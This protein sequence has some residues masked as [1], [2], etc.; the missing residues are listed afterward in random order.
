MVP[1]DFVDYV[2]DDGAGGVTYWPGLVVHI[3]PGND[4]RALVAPLDSSTP[5]FVA[6]YVLQPAGTDAIGILQAQ[7]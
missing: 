6:G 7:S 3:Y 5:P 2:A 4:V 1:G